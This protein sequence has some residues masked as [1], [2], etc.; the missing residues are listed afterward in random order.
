MTSRSSAENSLVALSGP[1][2][3]RLRSSRSAGAFLD[4]VNVASLAL[5]AVVTWDLGRS[6][7]I[8][9]PALCI[10]AAGAVALVQ[11]KTNSAWLVI[12]GALAGVATFNAR[13]GAG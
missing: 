1:L 2:V 9:A 13:D 10:A 5:M 11:F 3:P 12:G 7:L 4:A 8:D 6:A